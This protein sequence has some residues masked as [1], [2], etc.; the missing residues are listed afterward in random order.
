MLTDKIS[1]YV[2]VDYKKEMLIKKKQKVVLVSVISILLVIALGFGAYFVF[3]NK[4][5]ITTLKSE[6]L[7]QEI[8]GLFEKHIMLIKTEI[9]QVKQV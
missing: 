9:P 3:F 1:D 4:E 6:P 5:D 8:S 7:K 2:N